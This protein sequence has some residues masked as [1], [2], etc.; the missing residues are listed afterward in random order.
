MATEIPPQDF[1]PEYLYN[2]AGT[3]LIVIASIFIPLEVLF[4]AL[5]TYSRALNHTEMG[6]DDILIWPSLLV[7]LALCIE[8]IGMW[9]ASQNLVVALLMVSKPWPSMP[10]LG[11]T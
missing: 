3:K 6:L 5:R 4:V 8:S 7:C 1:A 2:Y 10:A 9:L 11:G